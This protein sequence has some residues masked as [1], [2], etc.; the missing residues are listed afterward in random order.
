MDEN[1]VYQHSA[2][3][4]NVYKLRRSYF[5]NKSFA[6]CA[7]THQQT[8]AQSSRGAV[9]KHQNVLSL[10]R[11][12]H[13]ELNFAGSDAAAKMIIFS[14]IYRRR[15]ENKHKQGSSLAYLY[16]CECCSSIWRSIVWCKQ[17]C[18]AA[19]LLFIYCFVRKHISCIGANINKAP[20][21]WIFGRGKRS[22]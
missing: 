22:R 19:Q 3:L 10:A 18:S 17:R 5:T 15:S 11:V 7:H 6:S 1:I 16:E 20:I 4:R 13:C 21:G 9:L 14:R 12:L 8:Q 2:C